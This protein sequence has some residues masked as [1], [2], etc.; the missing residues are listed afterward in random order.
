MPSKIKPRKVRKLFQGDVNDKA[1]FGYI[2]PMGVFTHPA[3]L[4][5]KVPG[6]IL[7]RKHIFGVHIFSHGIFY[8]CIFYVYDICPDFSNNT[9][10]PSLCILGF[11]VSI[12]TD[13]PKLHKSSNFRMLFSVALMTKSFSIIHIPQRRIIRGYFY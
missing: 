12:R 11:V 9:I 2:A 10:L 13:T 1:E 8:L 7:E 5:I 6:T 4:I 3:S